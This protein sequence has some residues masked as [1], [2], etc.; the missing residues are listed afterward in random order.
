MLSNSTTTILLATSHH[1]FPLNA[2]EQHNSCELPS[3]PWSFTQRTGA[4]NVENVVL[5]FETG[6]A[7]S[8]SCYSYREGLS[9]ANGPLKDEKKT[10]RVPSVIC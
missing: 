6:G 7:K 8:L 3:V 9:F 2:K 5:S 1:I 4:R 10:V